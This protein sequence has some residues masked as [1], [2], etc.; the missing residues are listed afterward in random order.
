M[1][2]VTCATAHTSP[3]LSASSVPRAVTAGRTQGDSSPTSVLESLGTAD[4]VT[5]FTAPHPDVSLSRVCPSREPR[6]IILH[7][8]STGLGFNIVGGEDG[9]GIFV[10]FI[11]AGGPADLSGELRRGDRILSVSRRGHPL[12]LHGLPQPRAGVC[13]TP[14]PCHPGHGSAGSIPSAGVDVAPG[15][16]ESEQ[17]P[18]RDLSCGGAGAGR[19]LARLPA[20]CIPDAQAGRGRVPGMPVLE[21]PVPG[22]VLVAQG[23]GDEALRVW[24]PRVP[25]QGRGRRCRGAARR[26]DP[27]GAS[28]GRSGPAE[29]LC[30]GR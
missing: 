9:E 3:G 27:V 19:V 14:V 13:R 16:V 8:G 29:P 15:C 10:S 23:L 1:S 5:R 17:Q 24:A 30:P 2:H 26:A 12:P 11:L 25:V 6:K 20:E 21:M 7:K 28:P 22:V 18:A 4:P